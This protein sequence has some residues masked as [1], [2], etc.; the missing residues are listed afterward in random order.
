M[1]KGLYVLIIVGVVLVSTL[2]GVGLFRA[3]FFTFV[4]N[5]QFAYVYDF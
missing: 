5:Y 4:D 3:M 2:I 1:P